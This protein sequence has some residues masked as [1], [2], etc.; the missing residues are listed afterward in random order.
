MKW[1]ERSSVF[2]AQGVTSNPS[3]QGHD[4]CGKA[5]SLLR[6]I[7]TAV[8]CANIFLENCLCL[9]DLRQGEES[10]SVTSSYKLYCSHFLVTCD[11]I[12]VLQTLM[13]LVIQHVFIECLLYAKHKYNCAYI[14]IYS[15]LLF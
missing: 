10:T 5:Y 7:H 9:S 6:K 14:K 2:L 4:G 11:F 15:N 1:L 12:N 3:S 13:T 8:I